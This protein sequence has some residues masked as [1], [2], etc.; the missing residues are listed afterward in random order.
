L[1]K[2]APP[3][4]SRPN[5][6]RTVTL[7]REQLSEAEFARLTAEGAKMSVDEAVAFAME[8]VS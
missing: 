3:P 8:A 6:E 5:R 1:I 4:A 2:A 7:L